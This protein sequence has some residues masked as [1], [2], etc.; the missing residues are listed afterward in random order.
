M[1]ERQRHQYLSVFG[2]DQYIPRRVL[3]GAR[4]SLQLPDE[5]LRSLEKVAKVVPAKEQQESPVKRREASDQAPVMLSNEP[6][7]SKS[8]LPTA[9]LTRIPQKTAQVASPTPTPTS[10]ITNSPTTSSQTTA[11]L[12]FLLNIWRVAEDCL[13]IDSRQPATALPT[14]RL[15]QNIL[16]AIGYPMV[17]LPES[18]IIRWPIFSQDPMANDEEQARAMVQAFISAQDSKAAL[19]KIILMGEEATRFALEKSEQTFDQLSGQVHS[20]KLWQARIAVTPS[21]HSMLHE[22]ITKALAWQVLQTFI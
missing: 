20:H 8:S 2:I 5:A 3:P 16:R 17:Q 9:E 12:R 11:P 10:A 18:E 15:L 14:D 6:E 21:L 4:P 13:V 19:A 22:P 7:Q 1:L